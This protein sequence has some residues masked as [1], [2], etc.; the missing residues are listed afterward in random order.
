MRPIFCIKNYMIRDS[1]NWLDHYLGPAPQF[2]AFN[3]QRQSPGFNIN[4]ICCANKTN[5]EYFYIIL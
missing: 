1:L 2:S 4:D 3:S 5:N